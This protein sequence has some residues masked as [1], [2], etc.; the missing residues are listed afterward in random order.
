MFEDFAAA[1]GTSAG[2]VRTGFLYLHPAEDADGVAA[3][4]ARLRDLGIIVDVVPQDAIAERVPGFDLSG[5]G[6]AAFEHGA[7]YAD[8]H[9]VT[10]GLFRVA[11]RAGAQPHPLAVGELDA[12]LASVTVVQQSFGYD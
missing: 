6:V 3:S 11:T 7:G 2:F 9:A 8:P 5:V 10:D 4:A 12:S 1:T